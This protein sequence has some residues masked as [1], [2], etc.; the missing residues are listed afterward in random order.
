MS[1]PG[2]DNYGSLGSVLRRACG[3]RRRCAGFTLIELLVVVAII[4]LLLAMMLPSLSQAKLL[5]R[6]TVCMN[7][8]KG[9][10]SALAMYQGDYGDWAPITP[11]NMSLEDCDL[12]CGIV[13]AHPW[14]SWWASLLPYGTYKLFDCPTARPTERVRCDED[15]TSITHVNVDT[16]TLSKGSYGIIFQESLL[17]YKTVACDGNYYTDYYPDD[18]N[19]ERPYYFG[20]PTM[21]FA[22]STIPG[23]S[24]TDPANSV[25]A[26]DCYFTNNVPTYPSEFGKI[27]CSSLFPPDCLQWV[28]PGKPMCPGN[29]QRFADR[30]LGT[31]CL[32]LDGCVRNCDTRRLDAMNTGDPNCIWD[33]N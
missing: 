22:Y 15:L 16:G 19:W 7:N 13:E 10:G 14:K 24:W 30:H 6:R 23:V 32:F 20:Y 31:N 5:A 1:S 28:V 33:V 9:L 11:A 21:N 26:A 17:G 18:L 29:P 3:R 8:F 4:A 25:Y 27:G 2:C 12:G